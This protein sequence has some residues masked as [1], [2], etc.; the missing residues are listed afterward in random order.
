MTDQD[1]T[2]FSNFAFELRKRA[3]AFV[4]QM[5]DEQVYQL[6]GVVRNELATCPKGRLEPAYDFL[7]AILAEEAAERRTP[8][9]N[10]VQMPRSFPDGIPF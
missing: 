7:A 5:A 2:D 10:V 4:A 1:Y 3:E 9:G 6:A 8:K